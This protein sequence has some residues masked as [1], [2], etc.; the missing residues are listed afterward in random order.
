LLGGGE[1][2]LL[3]NP[4]GIFAHAFIADV[5]RGIFGGGG[6][7]CSKRRAQNIQRGFVVQ[8]GGFAQANQ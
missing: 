3:N 1:Y 5:Q 2:G 8:L 6:V 7:Q 4:C